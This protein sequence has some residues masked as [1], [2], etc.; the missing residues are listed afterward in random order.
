MTREVT[1]PAV[2][3]S[4][5]GILVSLASMKLSR[6]SNL[7]FAVLCLVV[8]VNAAALWPELSISRFDLNDNVFH[9]GLV[10][11]IVQA[12]EH[13]RSP[14]EQWSP[15]W[16][17]GYPVLRT[18]QPLAHILVA[19]V[20]FALGKAVSLGTV[21]VWMRFLSVV[22]L[23]LSFFYAARRLTLSPLAAAATAMLAPLVSTNFLYGMEYG[24]FTWA[25][26]GLFPQA[27]AMHLLLLALATAWTAVREGKRLTLAGILV[28]LTVLAHL[29]YGYIAALSIC[30]MA[31][32]PDASVS[33]VARIRRVSFVGVV[34]ALLSSFQLLPL[35]L[36]RGAINHSR[37]EPVWKWDSFGAGTVMQWFVTGDLLDFGRM[38]VLTVLAVSGALLWFRRSRR[39][40]PDPAHVFIALGA[41]LWLLFFFGRPFW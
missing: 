1:N 20:Y 3:R 21:F 13:G 33:R 17:L 8:V 19:A 38:P 12:I 2:Y 32:I 6:D 23:P 39:E 26:S 35:M 36:D 25:G 34:S 16:S 7:A 24:S 4:P 30:L 40:E 29:I 15:E 14:L 5:H 41:T 9:F 18:Y 27:I 31:V 37:W 22:L 11:R 28:A 10:E